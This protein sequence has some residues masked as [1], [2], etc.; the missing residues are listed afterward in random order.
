[1]Y[2]ICVFAGTGD[3]RQL[4]EAL[5]ASNADI[6]A[7]VATRYGEAL[8]GSGE[9][10]FSGRM[11][12]EA[13]AAFMREKNFDCVIDATHPYADIVTANI[14]R[15]CADTGIA[16]ERMARGA[17]S[18]EEDGVF[19]ENAEACAEYLSHTEGKI[20]LTTGSKDLPIYAKRLKD[21]LIVRVLPMRRSLEICE[22]CGIE[23][24]AIIA[25]QGPFS[26]DMNIAML[27]S[28]GAKYMVTKDGGSVGGY[29]EKIRAARAVGA[30]PVIIGRPPQVEGLSYDA[31]LTR[32]KEKYGIV[33]NNRRKTVYLAGIGMG[34]T[35]TRTLGCERA[36]R[37]AD[38][39]I[40]AKRMLECFDTTGK[41]VREAVLSDKIIECVRTSSAN[42]FTV[43]LSGDTGFYSGAKK[44]AEQLTDAD[45][46]ILPGIGSLS[47]FCSRLSIPWENVRAISLH[48]RECNFAGEVRANE[49]VFALLG[50]NSGANRALERL[51]R[52]GLG[53]LEVYIGSRLG[54]SD[55]QIHS[56]IAKDLVDGSFDPLSVLIVHNP[57]A[58]ARIVTCGLEDEAFDRDEVPMTK[59]EVR[60]IALSKLQLTRNAIV[61]DVG[62][63][64]GSVTVECALQAIGGHV[65][66]IEVK[67]T[68]VALTRHNAE[69]FGCENLTVIAGSAPEA[70]IDLPAPTH[71]FIGGSRGNM[72]QIIDLVLAKSP[73]CR[74]VATAVTLETVSELNQ[75]SREFEISDIAQI[76]VTKTRGAGRFRLFAAQNPVY[77]YTM[78]HRKEKTED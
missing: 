50:G 65:Y 47:Y 31:L 43:L 7:C 78:Q 2:K 25:M 58:N 52:S 61:Y 21:R 62:S 56:G 70:L 66:G 3:G 36:V 22:E 46:T 26:C 11:D 41:E 18:S 73:D 45:V 24:A 33:F 23:P 55:E 51:C 12:A 10:V 38:C 48:G 59:S 9:D 29:E 54:Y 77:I 76:S 5:R 27:K 16:Y 69:K 71:V 32:L 6:T 63:G 30:I 72:R 60:A 8:L 67:D 28:C 34:S 4:V 35:D 42:V 37:E 14:A 20:L 15:A 49:Y 39:V 1:M 13:M 19:L 17:K 74:I 44:L 68:A 53:D 64:S 75:L 57:R 40:G